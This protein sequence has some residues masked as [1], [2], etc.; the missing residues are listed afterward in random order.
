VSDVEA[1]K[2]LSSIP[3]INELNRFQIKTERS[4]KVDFIRNLF[5]INIGEKELPMETP[6]NREIIDKLEDTGF[7]KVREKGGR[8]IYR[9]ENLMVTIHGKD[10]DRPTKGTYGAIKRQAGW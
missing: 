4:I 9:K 2:A 8:R 3:Y 10:N 6:R 1:T 7:V 5:I